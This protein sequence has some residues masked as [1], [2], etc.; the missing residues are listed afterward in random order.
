MVFNFSREKGNLIQTSLPTVYT[1]YTMA[2][3][4]Y[5]AMSYMEQDKL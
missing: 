1:V 3:D 2:N 5:S 4:D